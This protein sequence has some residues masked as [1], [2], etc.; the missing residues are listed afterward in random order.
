[1]TPNTI[2]RTLELAERGAGLTSP[3]AMCGAL[4]VKNGNI[5]GEGFLHL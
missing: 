2:A 1:M 4:I 5:V 3:G